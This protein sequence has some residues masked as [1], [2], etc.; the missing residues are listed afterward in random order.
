LKKVSASLWL[1][2][3]FGVL[4]AD[5]SYLVLNDYLKSQNVILSLQLTF[6]APATIDFVFYKLP[7]LLLLPLAPIILIIMQIALTGRITSYQLKNDSKDIP[8]IRIF[9]YMLCCTLTISYVNRFIYEILISI[10]NPL[11]NESDNNY[12][13]LDILGTFIPL[14]ITIILYAMLFQ[15]IGKWINNQKNRN[16]LISYSLKSTTLA[17]LFAGSFGSFCPFFISISF[18][19]VFYRNS[20]LFILSLI[21]T[22]ITAIRL[23]VTPVLIVLFQL[24]K[25]LSFKSQFTPLSMKT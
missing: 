23:S 16:N 15:L 17:L 6:S 19:P 24:A 14:L 7:S 2:G 10:Y 13:F 11:I 21:S 5:L 12:L 22:L 1:V 25:N 8:H 18:E 20:N 9:M 4:V 3:I